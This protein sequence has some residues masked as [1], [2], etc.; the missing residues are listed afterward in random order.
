MTAVMS[1]PD[2]H[3]SRASLCTDFTLGDDA[4]IQ[5]PALA[6]LYECL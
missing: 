1:D 6:A 4:A 5:Q 2:A 3:V